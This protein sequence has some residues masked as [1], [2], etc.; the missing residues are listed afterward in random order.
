MS[1]YLAASMVQQLGNTRT[2]KQLSIGDMGR[3]SF[4]SCLNLFHTNTMFKPCP[5]GIRPS[6]RFYYVKKISNDEYQYQF[7]YANTEVTPNTSGALKMSTSCDSI[8]TIKQAKVEAIHSDLVCYN[9][10][11]ERLLIV[12]FYWPY[13]FDKSK[14]GFY[15]LKP[16]SAYKVLDDNIVGNFVYNL[17]ITPKPGLFPI[18]K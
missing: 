14:L 1:A 18:K 11:E 2:N 12:Y 17:V 3:I 13:N 9:V 5:F 15:M 16:K 8:Q 6:M 7:C 10:G 4:A